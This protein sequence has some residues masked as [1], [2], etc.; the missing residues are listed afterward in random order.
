[1]DT[2]LTKQ[3][4]DT[5]GNRRSQKLIPV[6]VATLGPNSSNC[7]LQLPDRSR[8]VHTKA[9]GSKELVVFR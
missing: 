1:M 8:K 5:K 2:I 3:Q 7:C 4:K 9:A 6:T